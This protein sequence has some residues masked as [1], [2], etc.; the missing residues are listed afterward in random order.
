VRLVEDANNSNGCERLL[1]DEELACRLALAMAN[2]QFAEAGITTYPC[3]YPT[4]EPIAPAA[5]QRHP[6]T[7]RC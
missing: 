5:L 1:D 2:C 3:T 4:A 7:P 6:S